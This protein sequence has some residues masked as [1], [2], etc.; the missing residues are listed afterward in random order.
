MVAAQF[1]SLN[2][3]NKWRQLSLFIQSIGINGGNRS[4]YSLN[5]LGPFTNQPTRIH[6]HP[7]GIN[8]Q[9]IKIPHMIQHINPLNYVHPPEPVK[10]WQSTEKCPTPPPH[11]TCT[12][13]K[14]IAHS[15][16]TL[17]H[18]SVWSIVAR[19]NFVGITIT[20]HYRSSNFVKQIL[21]IRYDVFVT[22]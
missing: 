3:K 11:H 2:H 19:Q 17:S 8:I 14:N 21:D 18:C 16:C 1:I 6:P 4:V 22:D 7:Q 12:Q 5:F 10:I 20:S 9:I 15:S 13:Q